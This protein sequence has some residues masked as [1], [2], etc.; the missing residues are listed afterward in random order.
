M[1]HS[2][3]N[4]MDNQILDLP[5]GQLVTLKTYLSMPIQT[6]SE[7]LALPSGFVLSPLLASELARYR[8]LF[9]TVGQNWL[10]FSRLLMDDP[11]LFEELNQPSR[12]IF[13]LQAQG[14]DC[15]LLELFHETAAN[16]SDPTTDLAFLGLDLSLRGQGLGTILVRHAIQL[17]A[18]QGATRLSV[19]TCQ[20]DDPLALGFYQARGFQ[21]DKLALEILTD[22]RHLGLYPKSSAPHIPLSPDR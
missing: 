11:H 4:L 3:I 15:G 9:S 16:R 2:P 21:I 22:P 1:S 5:K 12:Q 10:W 17:A 19:N 8:T 14:R 13:A 18:Q 6:V 20:L 7:P